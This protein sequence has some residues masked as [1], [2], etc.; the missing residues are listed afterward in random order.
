MAGFRREGDEEPW[1]CGPGFSLVCLCV[2]LPIPSPSS[3]TDTNVTTLP[4]EV[5]SYGTESDQREVSP[6]SKCP[7]NIMHLPTL[8]RL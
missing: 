1:L 5:I 8:S 4:P 3:Y 6:V 2:A 7:L